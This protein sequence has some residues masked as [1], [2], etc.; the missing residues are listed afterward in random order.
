VSCTRTGRSTI[1]DLDQSAM[2]RESPGNT[3]TN[4][5]GADDGDLWFADA[6]EAVGQ[7]AAPFAGM[8]QTGSTGVISAATIAAPLAV[9]ANDG[10]FRASLQALHGTGR[11]QLVMSAIGT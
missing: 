2:R 1:K 7:E 6:N 8:T 5:A 4:D 3:E 10:D 9:C 11:E